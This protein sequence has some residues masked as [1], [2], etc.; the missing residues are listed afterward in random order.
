M[1][2]VSTLVDV[3]EYTEE[4]IV[5][6][7]RF[8]WNLLLEIRSIKSIF[9]LK[10]VRCKSPQLARRELWTMIQAYKLNRLTSHRF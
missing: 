1:D 9:N 2:I 4:Q 10:Y 6:L 3:A 8:R 7:Y 5:E